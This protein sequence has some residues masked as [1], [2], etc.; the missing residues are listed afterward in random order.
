VVLTTYRTL[1]TRA[2]KGCYVFCAD[3]ETREYFRTPLSRE[4]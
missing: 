4:R 1:M 3:P 2:L